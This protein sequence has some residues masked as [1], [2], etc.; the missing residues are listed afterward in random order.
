M[1]IT[2]LKE[3]IGITKDEDQRMVTASLDRNHRNK[4][5]AVIRLLPRFLH[6]SCSSEFGERKNETDLQKQMNR[7][8]FEQPTNC[9]DLSLLSFTLNGF[10]LVKSNDSTT[11]SNSANIDIART[12]VRL[13]GI[14]QSKIKI[15]FPTS[16]SI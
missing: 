8:R 16:S 10:Y 4:R 1:E 13:Q 7:R 5:P 3:T 15:N 14:I 6:I 12:K 9:S 2:L 11:K